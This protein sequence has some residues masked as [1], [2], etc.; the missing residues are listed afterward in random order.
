MSKATLF[1][2]ARRTLEMDVSEMVTHG[3]YSPEASPY[4]FINMV[5]ILDVARNKETQVGQEPHTGCQ[6]SAT[7][8]LW[9]FQVN[10]LAAHSLPAFSMGCAAKHWS[11]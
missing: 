6:L 7:I 3:G 8:F 2:S 5:R 10:C 11:L 1:N 9:T 4:Y